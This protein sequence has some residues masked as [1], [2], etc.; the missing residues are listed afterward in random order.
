MIGEKGGLLGVT[1]T[2]GS[3][4]HYLSLSDVRGYVPRFEHVRHMPQL[5]GDTGKPVRVFCLSIVFVWPIV[6]ELARSVAIILPIICYLFIIYY[7]L[8]MC[9]VTDM[10]HT[11][12]LITTEGTNTMQQ[13]TR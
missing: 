1:S 4:L 7:L 3:H 6:N 11:R 5:Q 9:T 12:D 8:L 10:T 2:S 13:G